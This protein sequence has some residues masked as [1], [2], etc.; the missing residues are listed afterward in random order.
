MLGSANDQTTAEGGAIT[1]ILQE[2]EIDRLPVAELQA[3]LELFLQPVLQHLL[4]QRLRSAAK[5]AVQGIVGSQSPLLTQMAQGVVHANANSFG[6]REV[7]TAVSI[8]EEPHVAHLLFSN[9]QVYS[10]RVPEFVGLHSRTTHHRRLAQF[11]VQ[12]AREMRN[13]TRT[14]HCWKESA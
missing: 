11:G 12:S 1:S 10:D 6:S 7:Q 4:E 8:G 3:G 9:N 13:G 5:L 14:S 2:A